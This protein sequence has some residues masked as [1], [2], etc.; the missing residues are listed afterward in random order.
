M[1]R[2]RIFRGLIEYN[3]LIATDTYQCRIRP[4]LEDLFDF[5][6]G[7]FVTITVGN[8]IKRSYSVGSSPKQN[9]IDLIV[10]TKIGGPGSQFFINAKG[11]QEVDLLGPLGTF[12]Y[13]QTDKPL[14]FWATG[15]GIVP[16]MS[17]IEDLLLNK[18]FE[19]KIVLNI[20]FRYLAGV[21]GKEY[22]EGLASKYSNLEYNLFL[23]RP[24]ENWSGKTG[25]ITEY[26]TMNNELPTFDHYLCGAKD[27]IDDI[28]S[29][30]IEKG[31]E[32]NNIY[33][34]KY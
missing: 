2:P 29:K 28:S 32:K 9:Y 34:E 14:M 13:R 6:P 21:V 1:I 30:L 11:G 3:K 8:M 27:M 17:M 24:E 23:T 19:K 25:R 12:I 26:L 16:F 7:Q 10:D 15:T 22:F 31:V 5:E 33:Y 4:Q 20:G 18:K